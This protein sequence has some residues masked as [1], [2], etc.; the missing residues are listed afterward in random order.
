MS[1][2]LVSSS[3]RKNLSNIIYDV[4]YITYHSQ[5]T[6]K[7]Q[8]PGAFT[9]NRHNPQI[10]EPFIPYLKINRPF[11]N[12]LPISIGRGLAYYFI[13]LHTR[14]TIYTIY[15]RYQHTIILNILLLPLTYNKNLVQPTDHSIYTS[16]PPSPP[17]IKTLPPYNPQHEFPI[18]Q[19]NPTPRTQHYAIITQSLQIPSK[20]AF[21]P[22]LIQ[23]PI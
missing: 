22:S 10:L 3:Q 14:Y 18:S 12:I 15:T 1:P 19:H 9:G 21:Q 4:V 2:I 6:Q 17:Y 16:L 20:V 7:S 8:I 23:T 13:V 5:I 11:P